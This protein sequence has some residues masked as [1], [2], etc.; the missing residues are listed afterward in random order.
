MRNLQLQVSAST[1]GTPYQIIATGIRPVGGSAFFSGEPIP[2][3]LLTALNRYLQE[4]NPTIGQW[5]YTVGDTTY[6]VAFSPA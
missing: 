5:D 2:W 6:R 1:S 4:F 3:E